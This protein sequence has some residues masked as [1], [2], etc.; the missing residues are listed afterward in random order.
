MLDRKNTGKEGCI[1][2]S[3]WPYL[4]LFY[5]LAINLLAF[6]IYG[7]DKRKAKRDQWRV[8]EKT[9]FLL[10][11]LGGSVGALAGMKVFHHKTR[12]WYFRFG[13]PLILILQ[14]AAVLLVSAYSAGLLHLPAG[15]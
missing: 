6:L 13:I 12:K 8:P 7:A 4:P 3:I 14:I 2:A 1:M 10:A 11:L 15:F 9:L 5:L